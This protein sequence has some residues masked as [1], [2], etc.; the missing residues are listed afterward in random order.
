M[1]GLGDEAQAIEKF[2]K[3]HILLKNPARKVRELNH[4]LTDL[5]SEADQLSPSL[6]LSKYAA[7]MGRY[8]DYY[9]HRYP[10][11]KV[12]IVSMDSLEIFE[13]DEFIMLVERLFADAVRG[14][15]L[16]W[17][18]LPRNVLFARPRLPAVGKMD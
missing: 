14:K 16:H 2:L 10:D 5:L 17:P 9:R 15:V 18:L 12:Q 1:V 7:A 3:A 8:Q 4:S 11:N 13:L 6:G